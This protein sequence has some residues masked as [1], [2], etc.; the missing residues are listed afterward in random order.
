[1]GKKTG[2]LKFGVGAAV[3]VMLGS[4]APASAAVLHQR[5]PSPDGYPSA[6]KKVSYTADGGYYSA[7]HFY[8]E[9]GDD[10]TLVVKW[11]FAHDAITSYSVTFTTNIPSSLE[12]RISKYDS[13]KSARVL[14]AG[15]Y[16]TY[17]SGVLNNVGAI[18]IGGH[19]TA[20]GGSRFS[21]TSGAG[22]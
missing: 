8:W 20:Q 4:V 21:D 17:E 3:C 16:G 10:A 19:V 18:G 14:K 9:P 5:T 11:C 22:G 2:L 7:G 6:C 1:M 12:P 15:L 13:L